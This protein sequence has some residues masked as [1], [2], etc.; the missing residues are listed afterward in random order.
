M[1]KYEWLN[2]DESIKYDYDPS[3]YVAWL[4]GKPLIRGGIEILEDCF[5]LPSF[6]ITKDMNPKILFKFVKEILRIKKGC[7]WRAYVGKNDL[8][9]QD[10]AKHFKFVPVYDKLEDNLLL[11]ERV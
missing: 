10:F 7:K 1:R 2:W 3:E 5:L 4:H 6:A 8:V 9:A 11:Y